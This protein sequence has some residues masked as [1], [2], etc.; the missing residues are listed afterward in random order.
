MDVWCETSLIFNRAIVMCMLS[1]HTALE[2]CINDR[3]YHVVKILYDSKR[4][5]QHYL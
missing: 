5:L 4:I 2:T 3:L 1:K